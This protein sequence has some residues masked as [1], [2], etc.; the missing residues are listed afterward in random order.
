MA[1]LKPGLWSD[2]CKQ[3]AFVEGAKWAA[4]DWD[5]PSDADEAQAEAIKRYGDPG[6]AHHGY[7]CDKDGDPMTEWCDVCHRL[8]KEQEKIGY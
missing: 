8:A 4:A 2:E 3:R 1:P 5:N 6:P 7:G